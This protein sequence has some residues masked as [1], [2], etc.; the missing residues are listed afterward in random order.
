MKKITAIALVVA[1]GGCGN[2]Q[3]SREEML[4]TAGGALLGGV[5]GYQFG[6]GIIMPALYA[7]AGTLV[8]GTA[9]YVTTRALMG[10]DRAA[11][12][13]TTEMGLNSAQDG[14]IVEWKN[15]DTGNTGIFRATSSYRNANGQYCR[16]YRSTVAFR[17]GVKSGDG[18]ACQQA[19]GTWKVV[20]DDFS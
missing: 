8:G 16:K 10:T 6:G 20:T 1:L 3:M 14:Q 17:E 7:T 18:I 19:D 11:Y 2:V 5:I 9:G 15:P 4:G 12:K 13:N